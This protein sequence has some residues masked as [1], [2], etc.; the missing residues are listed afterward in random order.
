MKKFLGSLFA[1]LTLVFTLTAQAAPASAHD[2]V[3]GSY[4]EAN[5]SVEAG[6]FAVSVT[7][8]EDVMQVA[9]NAGIAIAITGPDGTTEPTACLSVDGPQISALASLDKAGDYTVDW[10]S[11]SNDGHPNSGT[12]K[13]T[14]TNTTGFVAED[15][16]AA[17]DASRTAIGSASPM[18]LIAPGPVMYDSASKSDSNSNLTWIGLGIGAGLIILGSVFGAL[19][20]RAK[21]RKQESEPEILTDDE[22]KQ[23]S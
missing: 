15:T 8:N 17:C 23:N 19:R 22:P 20:L 5:S 10:R 18:P 1:A 21:E 3:T 12:F 11:V 2:E 9:D 6:T 16:A 13:F 14:L 4:P 7:F